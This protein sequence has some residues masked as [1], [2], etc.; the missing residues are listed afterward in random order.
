MGNYVIAAGNY[1]TVTRSQVGNYVIADTSG[2]RTNS[3]AA[4]GSGSALPARSCCRRT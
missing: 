2:I 3:P 4:S 1:V